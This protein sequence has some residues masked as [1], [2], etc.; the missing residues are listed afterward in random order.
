MLLLENV[1]FAV[2]NSYD[3]YG[4][5]FKIAWVFN[6]VVVKLTY[7]NNGIVATT[8]LLYSNGDYINNH[9]LS[10]LYNINII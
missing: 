8:F 4:A 7:G 2:Q 5:Y 1:H 9:I 10:S 6:A 3:E